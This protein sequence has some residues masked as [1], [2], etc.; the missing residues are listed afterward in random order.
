MNAGTI[1][2]PGRDS[3]MNKLLC[4]RE[5]ITSLL[6]F[7]LAMY[8]RTYGPTDLLTTVVATGIIESLFIKKY[9]ANQANF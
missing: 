8:L 3:F 4:R 2:F 7:L 1:G 9:T 6:V 5:K